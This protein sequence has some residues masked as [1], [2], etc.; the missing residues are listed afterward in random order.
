[1]GARYIRVIVTLNSIFKKRKKK[2]EDS[3]ILLTVI[4]SH[5]DCSKRFKTFH[6]TLSEIS[7]EIREVYARVS[8]AAQLNFRRRVRFN[9]NRTPLDETRV[10]PDLDVPRFFSL[11]SLKISKLNVNSRVY[12]SPRIS[13]ESYLV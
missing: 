10:R 7:R 13:R 6:K 11:F 8:R 1:M 12:E 4:F 3:L 2:N 9:R 5:S